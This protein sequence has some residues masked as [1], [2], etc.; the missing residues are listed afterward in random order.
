[1]EKVDEPEKGKSEERGYQGCPMK[2]G[3]KTKR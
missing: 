3:E 2:N 1:M